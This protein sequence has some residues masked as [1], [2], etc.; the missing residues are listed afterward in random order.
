MGSE[1][2]R[3]FSDVDFE[4]LVELSKHPEYAEVMETR[5]TLQT[6]TFATVDETNEH[7]FLVSNYDIVTAYDDRVVEISQDGNVYAFIEADHRG[8]EHGVDGW[9][10]TGGGPEEVI[11][12]MEMNGVRSDD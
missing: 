7:E 9:V 10:G 4:R 12:S 11:R 5:L 8:P 1:L 6:R 2:R 3:D